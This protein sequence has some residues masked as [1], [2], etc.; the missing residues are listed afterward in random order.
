MGW[1]SFLDRFAESG[2]DNESITSMRAIRNRQSVGSVGPETK[3]V[4]WRIE[5]PNGPINPWGLSGNAIRNVS[6]EFKRGFVRDKN[7]KKVK[8]LQTSN[9]KLHFKFHIEFAG[10]S[11]FLKSVCAEIHRHVSNLWS[12]ISLKSLSQISQISRSKREHSQAPPII[13]N[14]FQDN[15]ISFVVRSLR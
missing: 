14:Y 12:Q 10:F 9:F 3:M 7:I 8:R 6:I 11:M 13:L 1:D 15:P 5:S 4:Q 2:T